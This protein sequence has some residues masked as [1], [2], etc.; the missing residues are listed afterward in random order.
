MTCMHYRAHERRLMAHPND[1][2]RSRGECGSFDP[3]R[4]LRKGVI[5][6][7]PQAGPD[8]AG[9]TMIAGDARPRLEQRRAMFIHSYIA[10][11]RGHDLIA[12]ASRVR[13]SRD[14]PAV[15]YS[16]RPTGRRRAIGPGLAMDAIPAGAGGA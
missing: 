3:A 4:S 1:Q 10:E 12:A 9:C 14:Y 5:R 2:M 13:G 16:A 11:Q 15:L 8:G 6:S 7:L